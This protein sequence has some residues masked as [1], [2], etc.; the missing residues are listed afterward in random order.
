M[1]EP[2]ES[3]ATIPRLGFD[4]KDARSPKNITG[5]S[6][7]SNC[8]VWAPDSRQQNR[9][10]PSEKPAKTTLYSNDVHYQIKV[11]SY[12]LEKREKLR[13]AWAAYGLE[14][15]N[16]RLMLFEFNDSVERSIN[17]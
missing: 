10:E 6:K 4:F 17:Y 5:C 9:T 14:T 8:D 2:E 1:I 7:R 12:D 11:S 16:I 3:T 15:G 13:A